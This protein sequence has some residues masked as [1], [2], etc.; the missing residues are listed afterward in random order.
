MYE[1]AVL[2][3][4]LKRPGYSQSGLAKAL[5]KSD[6]SVSRMLRGQRQIKASEIPIIEQYLGG[7][8]LPNTTAHEEAYHLALGRVIAEWNT[9]EQSLRHILYWTIAAPETW[10]SANQ[11]HAL[12]RAIPTFEGRLEALSE[13]LK[14]ALLGHR[15]EMEMWRSLLH[16]LLSASQRRRLHAAATTSVIGPDVTGKPDAYY[17]SDAPPATLHYEGYQ[18]YT[19]TAEQIGEDLQ[20]FRRLRADLQEFEDAIRALGLKHRNDVVRT[21]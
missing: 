2:A 12:F 16:R 8:E 5:G 10:L 1:L 4:L 14:E 7:S 17:G 13:L 21:P 9:I 18:H 6:A 19:I 15:N 20:L 11:L 3:E